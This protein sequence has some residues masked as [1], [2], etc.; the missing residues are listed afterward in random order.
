VLASAVRSNTAVGSGASP[1]A[2]WALF[3]ALTSYALPVVTWALAPMKVERAK[4]ER[5][6]RRVRAVELEPVE[7]LERAA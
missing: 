5:R 7:I 6:R 4:P 2:T 1:L 3:A